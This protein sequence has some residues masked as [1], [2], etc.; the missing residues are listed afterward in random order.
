MFY[1]FRR[2]TQLAHVPYGYDGKKSAPAGSVLRMGGCPRVQWPAEQHATIS[3]CLSLA[4][5]KLFIKQYLF[6][7]PSA[8]PM[9]HRWWSNSIGV[10]HCMF[11]E[12]IISHYYL[13]LIV[14]HTIA[15]KCLEL[16]GKVVGQDEWGMC[17]FLAFRH[18]NW[19]CNLQKTGNI[20]HSDLDFRYDKDAIEE[21]SH[22]CFQNSWKIEYI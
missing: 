15:V 4:A 5:T 13:N 9:R 17:A 20:E 6:Y 7:Y 11:P 12:I 2:C 19:A 14:S 8:I 3:S 16:G 21:S 1:L 18:Q 10:K 22:L